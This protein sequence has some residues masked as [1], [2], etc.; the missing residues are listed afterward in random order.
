[1]HALAVSS[2]VFALVFA[3]SL[4]GMVIRRAA[5]ETHFTPEAKDTVRLA[6][7][8]VVTMT[9]LVLGMLVSSSK[10][11]YDGE[12]NQ[13]AEMSSQIILMNDLLLAYGPE[14]KQARVEAL[15][16]VE[17]AADRI[18]PK[19]KSALFQLRPEHH[20]EEFYKELQLLVPKNDEQASS[21]AQL[22]SL[23][24]S[25]KKSYWLLYLQTVQT[26]I[27]TPLLLVVTS[28]L[29]AI[30]VSFGIFAPRNLTVMVTL[31]VCAMAVSAAIFIIT[32]MYSPF[33]GVLKI[34]PAAVRDAVHQMGTER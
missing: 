1:M 25:A 2:L 3:G 8:L 24:M 20:S 30:F 22:V 34:S 11:F 10:T 26:P 19:D 15:E 31:I 23:T 12:K 9:G 32:S 7:G 28:W 17:Q 5:P 4:V 21:K 13:V 16:F 6:I 14:T 27:P 29:V 18:W 33:T